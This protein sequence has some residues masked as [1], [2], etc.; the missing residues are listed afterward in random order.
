MV[1][2]TLAKAIAQWPTGD[3]A[4]LLGLIHTEIHRRAEEQRARKKPKLPRDTGKDA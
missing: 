3:L 1:P 4:D 2:K